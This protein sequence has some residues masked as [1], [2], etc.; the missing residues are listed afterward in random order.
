MQQLTTVDAY[1]PS[2]VAEKVETLG[3]TKATLPFYK[4]LFLGFLGGAFIALGCLYYLTATA[5]IKAGSSVQV[6]LGGIVFTLG[7]MLVN[8]G[9][10]E[11]FTGNNL[12]TMACVARKITPGQLLR[13][14]AIVWVGNFIGAILTALFAYWA[15]HYTYP[16]NLVGARL[17]YV[18]ASKASLSF[19]LAFMRGVMANALVCLG[20]W[21]AYAGRSV[22]DKIVGLL[23]P[24][25]AFVAMGFEHSV[26]N[27]FF[28]TYGLLIKNIPDVLTAPGAPAAAKLAHLTV[29]GFAN[30]V[31]AATLGN[32]IGGG[33]L[34]G[35]VYWV[36]YRW[37]GH[38]LAGADKK[39]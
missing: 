17:L 25:S 4:M 7:L 22:V 5:D 16:T 34:V 10:A 2:E 15:Q 27:M 3:I 9:G 1:A 36:I 33:V 14:W 31:V 20:M 12:M 11:L 23:L 39:K 8:V 13:A 21:V 19:G 32:V 38:K 30:N 18:S 29:G 6:V 35:L 37:E 24:I 26:A 28:I